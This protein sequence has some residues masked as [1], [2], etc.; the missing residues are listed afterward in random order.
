MLAS[1]NALIVYAGLFIG[2]LL[3]VEGLYRFVVDV[4]S[5]PRRRIN[6]R[7]TMLEQ[8]SDPRQ[9]LQALRRRPSETKGLLTFANRLFGDFNRMIAQAGLSISPARLLVWQAT[10]A[11]VVCLGLALW[12][13]LPNLA[14]AAVGAALGLGLP[15]L[16][17]RTRRR[18][19]LRLF[20]E[21]LPTALDLLVR[22]LR[23]GHPL[24][25][26]LSVVA[27]ELPDPIGSE[28]GMVVDE[29][30]YGLDLQEAIDNLSRRIDLPDLRYMTIAIN[31]QHESGGNLAEVLAGLSK[32][33]RDRLQMF[34]K[35]KAVSAEG[36][37]SAMF[38]SI[39]PFVLAGV[40][41]MINPKYY[42]Q[43]S[44]DPLFPIL[45]VLTVVLLIINILV[46]R[47]LVNF[48]V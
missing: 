34:R 26:S 5:G 22:S 43:V 14:V 39:F 16:Y 13:A 37:L 24:S 20:G 48:K 19:R 31:I 35:I 44:D 18:R 8:G 9:V 45:A 7:M 25:A 41:W 30:T 1:Y 33:I 36:R 21:Q 38:L 29:V 40:L 3:L 12:T 28:V 27:Q 46:M 10:L 4:Q 6:R 11:G 2:V 47:W 42:Q 15:L 23:I 17:I 32:V